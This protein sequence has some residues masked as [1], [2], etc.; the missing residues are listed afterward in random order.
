MGDG[1]N[2]GLNDELGE[3]R[4]SQVGLLNGPDQLRNL[5]R[6]SFKRIVADHPNVQEVSEADV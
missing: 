1:E 5:L 2:L 4:L 3:A 6:I